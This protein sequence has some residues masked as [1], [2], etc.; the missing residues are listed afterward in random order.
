[1]NKIDSDSG[2]Y[3]ANNIYDLQF[4]KNKFVMEMNIHKYM[5]K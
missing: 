4:I 1:M 2:I 3:C 5:H